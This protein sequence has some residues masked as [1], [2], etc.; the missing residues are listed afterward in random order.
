MATVL[1]IIGSVRAVAVAPLPENGGNTAPVPVTNQLG[2]VALAPQD[3]VLVAGQGTNQGGVLTGSKKLNGPWVFQAA[4]IAMIRP[5]DFL[6]ATQLLASNM[7]VIVNEGTYASTEWRI[8]STSAGN[9]SA[10]YTVGTHDLIFGLSQQ[11][12]DVRLFGAKVF[13][14]RRGLSKRVVARQL[15]LEL[16]R[17]RLTRAP[18]C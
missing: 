7:L 17:H 18:L 9:S 2:G 14:V 15:R 6:T 4:G 8:T 3:R 5:P 16:S 11:H 13:A 1:P 12:L 10:A